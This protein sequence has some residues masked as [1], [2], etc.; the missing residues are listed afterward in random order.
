MSI[1]AAI[2]AGREH[3]ALRRRSA[4]R[5]VLFNPWPWMLA[6]FLLGFAVR[7]EADD[8]THACEPSPLMLPSLELITCPPDDEGEES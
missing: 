1:D 4:I 2:D 7:A 3:A 5:D 8:V 6:A